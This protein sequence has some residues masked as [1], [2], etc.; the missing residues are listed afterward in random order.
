M[1][2]EIRIVSPLTDPPARAISQKRRPNWG[3]TR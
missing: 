2:R 3:T 1:K